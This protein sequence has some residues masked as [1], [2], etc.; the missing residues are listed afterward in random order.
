MVPIDTHFHN[1]KSEKPWITIEDTQHIYDAC[2]SVPPLLGSLVLLPKSKTN[3]NKLSLKTKKML[4]EGANS[5]VPELLSEWARQAEQI[6][7]QIEN[8]KMRSL[9]D[10]DHNFLSEILKDDLAIFTSHHPQFKSL[11]N[12]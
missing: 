3:F 1:H 5:I 9:T 10:E 12:L 4:H 7:Q 11:W 6:A 2:P 8:E